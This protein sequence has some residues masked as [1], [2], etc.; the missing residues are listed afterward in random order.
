VRFERD[1]FPRPLVFGDGSAKEV[2]ALGLTSEVRGEG[3]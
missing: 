2:D 3:D 1:E